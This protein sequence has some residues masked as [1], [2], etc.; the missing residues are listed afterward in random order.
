M[1]V[2]RANKRSPPRRP[3]A[4]WDDLRAHNT[5]LLLAAIWERRGLSRADLA[6]DSGLSRGTV[7]DIV[8]GFIEA[9]L[10][11]ETDDARPRAASGGRPPTD[12]RFV[13][14]C[15]HILGVELG[16]SHI[17]AVRTD[18]RG[19]VVAREAAEV[20]VS[21]DPAGTLAALIATARALAAAEEAVPLIGL[22]LA[23]PTP[24]RIGQG[25]VL[26]P[27][28]FPRWEGIDLG[29]ALEEALGLPV[30]ADN[31][32]NLGALAEH[33][34]GAGRG[35]RD[36]AY[37]KVATGVGAGILIDGE[38]YRGAAGIA[39]EI[40]HTAIDPQ[41][42]RCRCGLRG[43]LEALVGTAYL[44]ERAE[45]A[46][47]AAGSRPAW[48]LPSPTVGSL[49]DAA[50]SGDPVA[51]GLIAD[52]GR[53]L[54]TAVANLLNLVNPARVILG[55]RLTDAGAILLPAL[56]AQVMTRALWTSV[57]GADVT[58]GQLGDEAVAIGAATAILR[59]SLREPAALLTPSLSTA[60]RGAA[61]ATLSP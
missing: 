1:F 25:A 15:R 29:L 27:H 8:G 17:C 10:V 51:A 35:V 16:A 42:A 3:A 48:A 14:G 43:C 5:A 22:G 39:G 21:G 18:L 9:G 58:I 45:A 50:R 31:D 53:H 34:W 55:G 49:I 56:H 60:H 32:A 54:G 57:A 13:D 38:I 41:G 61:A 26:S 20:D 47:V 11:E 37:I 6:R 2:R 40:G 4:G 7:G 28:L 19:R 12:L 23:L 46:L 33:W 44:L 59:Q 36:F 52:A 24:L 30:E